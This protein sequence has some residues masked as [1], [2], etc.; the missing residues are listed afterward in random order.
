LRLDFWS[1]VPFHSWWR[2]PITAIF[3]VR[4]CD[5]GCVTC[6]ASEAAFGRFMQL[7]HPLRRSPEAIAAQAAQ[8]GSMTRAP[9]FLVGELLDGGEDFARRTIEALGRLRLENRITLE[10]FAP[11]PEEFVDFIDG[12]LSN[13]SAELSPESHDPAVR[14]RMG[15]ASYSNAAMQEA[16]AALLASRC[17]QLDLFFMVGLPGQTYDSV[18]ATVDFV[19]DL[20]A[21]YDSRLSAFLTPMGPFLDPGSDGFENPEAHG[22]RLFAR[23]LAEHRALLENRDWEHILNYETRWMTRH[24]IVEAT[25]DAAER[26]NDLKQRYGRIDAGAAKRVRK[27]LAAARNIKAQ[28]EAVGDGALDPDLHAAMLGEIC[29]NSE[30]TI[31]A[32][33]E[34]F[35]PAAFLQNFR[36]GGCLKTAFGRRRRGP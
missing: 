33:A 15:K 19:G 26:L 29:A 35:P 22:Y 9:I 28:L 1:C 31:N 7:V 24:Q 10:F 36:I 12:C 8:L 30:E 2:H 32:K 20:F 11:P 34:L 16:I 5:R 25:Y 13:W 3:T 21:R 6:G 27:R 14:E 4:G 17:A 18:L 23:T